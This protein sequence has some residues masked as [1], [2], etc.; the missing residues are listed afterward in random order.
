[1]RIFDG[2]NDVLTELYE[3]GGVSAAPGFLTGLKG[4]VDAIRARGGG[5]AGGFFAMWVGSPGV[6]DFSLIEAAGHAP[7]ALPLATEISQRKALDT[8]LTQIDIIAELQKLEA[9]SLCTS[10]DGIEAAQADGRLAAVLHLEGAEAIGPDL[11]ELEAFHAAGLRSL[12]P[13]WSRSNIFGHGVPF[14]YPSDGETGPGLTD[15]GHA[16]I[17]K[18]NALR[19]MIDLSHLNAAGV[20]DVARLS[21]APLVA[22]HS[23]AHGVAPHAR[24]L[25]DAQLGLIAASGGVVGLNFEASFLRPDGRCLADVPSEVVM[26]HLD[27]LLHHLGEEGVAIGSDFDG[28]TP[29]DWL[30]SA[31]RLPALV[32]AMERQGYTSDR[33][34]RICWS[35]WMRVLR[36]TWGA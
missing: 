22:T 17:E 29:P 30:G 15:V 36:D 1:M 6:M 12:G 9:L 3:A 28:C 24:N 7:Y 14:R 10:V 26:A 23:N 25:T 11:A 13:V 33:I 21:D 5:F 34:E 2:H 18:C 31:D 8:I 4:H 20:R 27:H 19:I 16:L 35:N 32:A